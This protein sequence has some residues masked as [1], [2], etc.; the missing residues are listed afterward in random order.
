MAIKIA[1]VPNG[2]TI[3]TK[4][5]AQYLTVAAVHILEKNKKVKAYC[6]QSSQSGLMNA[7]NTEDKTIRLLPLAVRH[8]AHNVYKNDN[9]IG[10]LWGKLGEINRQL[11]VGGDY[12]ANFFK[13]F[14]Q[15][16]EQF[17]AQF[18]PIPNQLYHCFDQ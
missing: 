10:A 3:I 7:N 15:D 11:G 5:R 8:Y 4:E 14:K 16:L 18:E 13:Q 9:K 6:V 2:Y 12:L 1:I 17:V